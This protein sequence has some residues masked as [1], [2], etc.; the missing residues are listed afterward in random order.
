MEASKPGH[1]TM[2]QKSVFHVVS[3]KLQS[4]HSPYS[5]TSTIRI[6]NPCHTA[7]P[8]QPQPRSECLI[9]RLWGYW[10]MGLCV[11]YF[12]CGVLGRYGT[13]PLWNG[14]GG[15]EGCQT[16]CGAVR[17]QV[18]C[19]VN[20]PSGTATSPVLWAAVL[21]QYLLGWADFQLQGGLELLIGAPIPPPYGGMW[22]A[23]YR[24]QAHA[25]TRK[26]SSVVP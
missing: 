2:T 14:I 3:L 10:T 8:A 18:L 19:V 6:P 21:H 23:G 5:C 7:S 24:E 12:G 16:S 4:R 13:V 1:S 20:I 15:R 17:L 25:S 11:R 22:C 9:V 26:S